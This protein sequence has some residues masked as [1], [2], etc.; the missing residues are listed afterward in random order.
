MRPGT[1]AGNNSKKVSCLPGPPSGSLAGAGMS[2]VPALRHLTVGI[3]GA[4]NMGQAILAGLRRAGVPSAR[5][6]VAEVR[7]AT[8]SAVQR[9]FR[10]RIVSVPTLARQCDAIILA[11][12]PQDLGLVVALLR[13]SLGTQARRTLVISIAA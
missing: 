10:A 5:L 7:A 13:G 4:G 9:R 12:K 11:V 1:R 8:A 6:Y 2:H 3:I